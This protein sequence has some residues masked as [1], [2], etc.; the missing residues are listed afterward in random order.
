METKRHFSLARAAMTLLFTVLTM[1]AQTAWATITGRGV[2]A[3]PYVINDNSDWNTFAN[4]NNADIYWGSGVYVK[5]GADIGASTPVTSMVGTSSNKFKGTFDGAGHSLTVDYAFNLAEEYVAPFRFVDGVTI[6]NLHV[7]GSINTYKKFAGGL[8]AEVSGNC[9]I[10]NCRSSV[11][12]VG[13]TTGDGTHGGFIAVARGGSYTITIANCLFDGRL[14]GTSHSCG[15][16]VGWHE[17]NINFTGC[18]FNPSFLNLET[19]KSATFARNG[20]T[21]ILHCYYKTSFGEAQGTDASGMT[22]TELAAALNNGGAEWQVVDDN[23]LPIIVPNP[24]KLENATI[25]NVEPYYQYTGSNISITPVVK[26]ADGTVLTLG[27]DFTAK[28]NDSTKS[29]FPFSVLNRGEYTLTIT[30]K[31]NY[32]GSQTFTFAV[33]TLS[34]NT[35]YPE[36]DPRH[37]YIRMPKT[38]SKTLILPGASI[39]TF[40]VYDDG[41]G[42]YGY[43]A[44]CSGYLVIY[45]PKGYVIELSGSACLDKYH[46]YLT[47]YD[48]GQNSTKKLID[49]FKS[50]DW[51]VSTEIPTVY[52]TG[53]VMTLYFYSDDDDNFS[54]LNLTV[55]L[56]YATNNVTVNPATGGSVTA[57]VSGTTATTAVWNQTVDLTATPQSG[58]MLNGLSVKDGSNNNVNLTWDG[59]FY[60]TATFTMPFS[61]VTVTPTFTNSL[62]ADGGLYIDIPKTDTKSLTIPS[63]VQS[64]K[65]YD[66]GGKDNDHGKNCDGYLVLTAPSGY[67]MQLSG[68]C[69]TGAGDRFYIYDGDNTSA[70]TLISANSHKTFN[71]NS[72]G[73]IIMLRFKSNDDTSVSSGLDLT[74]TL[75]NPN[76]QLNVTVNNPATGGSVTTNKDKAKWNETVTLTSAP[77][78]G[79]LL[80]DLSVKDATNNN[81]SVGDMRWY[82]GNSTAT[83]TM[84][85]NDVTVTPTFTNNLTADGGLYINMLSTETLNVPIPSGVQS[86]KVYDNG[87]KNGNYDDYCHGTLVLTAPEGYALRLTGSITTDGSDYLTVYDNN[88]ASGTKLLNQVTSPSIGKTTD[89]TP[90]ISS[91]RSMTLYFHSGTN[92]VRAGLDLTVTVFVQNTDFNID[93]TPTTGGTITAS[94]NNQNVTSSKCNENVTLTSTPSDGYALIALTVTED[95]NNPIPMTD[96]LW[97]TGTNTATFSMPP[98]TVTVTP[99]F[100]E[101]TVD[102]GLY[103]N[104][105]RT[106]TKTITIPTGVQSFKVYDDG[107]SD[108]NYSNNTNNTLVLTAPEGYV[109]Q[110]SGSIKTQ[111]SDRLTV[112]DNSEAS[113]TTLIDPIEG[114]KT[115]T[116]VISSGQSMTLY[117]SANFSYDNAGLDLTVTLIKAVTLTLN[118]N[119]DN[120][121]VINDNSG[122]KSNVILDGRTLYK[123]G[124]WNTLTLPFSMTAEQIATSPLAD[125]NI[126]ELLT[127]SNLDSDGKLTL[128]FQNADAIVAGKPYMVKWADTPDLTISTL[129]EWE[130]FAT[131]VNGGTTYAGQV[132]KLAADIDGITKM[133]GTSS[134]KF[135][136]TFDGA[137]HTLTVNYNVNENVCA[138][139]RY[140]DG[141]TIKYLKVCGSI[142]NE[143]KQNAGIAGYSYGESNLISCHS[144]VIITSNY[145]GDASNA[146]LLVHVDGGTV[147]INNCAFTGKLL[148]KNNTN[149]PIKNGGLVGWTETNNGAKTKISNSLFDPKE[150]TM[151]GEK[152]LAR[153]RNTSSGLTINKCYYKMVFGDVQGTDAIGMDKETLIAN[154]HLGSG[155]EISGDNVVPKM[156]FPVS[157]I[158]NPQFIGVIIDNTENPVAF[159]G[160]SFKGNYAPLQITNANRNG[161]VLLDDNTLHYAAS[162]DNLGACRA[163]FFVDP[164]TVGGTRPTNYVMDFGNNETLT[165]TFPSISGDANGDGDVN[166]SDAVAIVNYI[167]GNP[168]AGFNAA[169]ADMNG[170]GKVTI[171]DAVAVVNMLQNQ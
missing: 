44:N 10:S 161:I 170:D 48:G 160:G 136:G 70:S 151:T 28:L 4:E 89:I 3:D 49:T 9:T 137:G 53:R 98:S 26:A 85:I 117:F 56:I 61:P 100:I 123:N 45:A 13:N 101:A 95:N 157:D 87:G 133:V 138:P 23:V 88:A 146:G 17:G 127:T 67:R 154:D 106:G 118:D 109:L 159:T 147:T 167:L 50:S 72:S 43:S 126:K 91:G 163:Y 124:E 62:T 121:T 78:S 2:A 69:S 38:D 22:A 134:N 93:I 112:Y 30:G 171:T 120:T 97:Y 39:S 59:P 142:T 65:V 96:M 135:K 155:W 144:D 140:I 80:T 143:G 63:G 51:N 20:V 18:Y 36:G 57:S 64:F 6:K 52:S 15:G 73:N 8:M 83:F 40:K 164:T 37:Y 162:G 76:E 102:G 19:Y 156:N 79:Y 114:F 150:L 46:D 107:G 54:G 152:T 111:S 130:A 77:Q 16:F 21:S 71:V 99:T 29:S 58:Y 168:T 86:F 35:Y 131:A 5:L 128:N 115:I 119:A 122:V 84:P 11:N 7:T 116:T 66:D 1:T 81:I 82:T 32:T 25:T 153:A 42:P 31:G 55:R 103:I 166:I 12:L 92:V 90:V 41:E 141:A 14:R 60:N 149:T 110:L 75:F 33:N 27:T 74:V 132:V 125:A 148:K 139:F 24:K 105:P 108:G 34:I 104:M 68:N 47:V 165:G 113:G 158:V 145:N 169:A 94:I 129:A